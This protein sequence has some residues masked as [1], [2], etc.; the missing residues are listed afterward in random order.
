MQINLGPFGNSTQTVAP[1]AD[2]TA[3]GDAVSNL[4]GAV[5]N[6]AAVH[7]QEEKQKADALNSARAINAHEDYVLRV[8]E[9]AT[10]IA[11]RVST[12]ELAPE[13]ATAE[14]DQQVARIEA[15]NLPNRTP[16]QQE[17]SAGIQRRVLA[18]NRD[19][20]AVAAHNQFMASGDTRLDLGLDTLQKQ[21][22][23]P[24]A[25]IDLLNAKGEIFAQVARRAGVPEEQ[26]ARKL[27][28]FKDQNWLNHATEGYLA[29]RDSIPALKVMEHDLTAADGFYA[30][31]ID[32][33]RRNTLLSQVLARRDHVEEEA[34]RGAALQEK[35]AAKDAEAMALEERL[36]QGQL[37]DP[38][39]AE[40][41]NFVDSLFSARTGG[42]GLAEGSPEWRSAAIDTATRTGIVPSEVDS[43]LRTSAMTPDPIAGANAAGVIQQ[44]TERNPQVLE[45]L[46]EKTK[47][48][49]L[50]VA[51]MVKSGTPPILAV[52]AVR[53]AVF[54]T[55]PQEREL[56]QQVYRKTVKD[57][58]ADLLKM[59]QSDDHYNTSLFARTPKPPIGMV[60]DFNLLADTYSATTKG[61]PKRAQMLAYQD[62]QSRWG[63]S[64]V[65]GQAEI[66]R[67]PPE[68]FGITPDEVHSDLLNHYG[69]RAPNITLLADAATESRAYSPIDG[70]A[71]PLSWALIETDPKTGT[72]SV[73]PERYA[74]PGAAELT[75]KVREA[76]AA[77]V[78]KA[79]ATA[80]QQ[81]QLEGILKAQ[82]N[83]QPS[84]SGSI[85]A[86]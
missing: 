35:Q 22:G 3:I 49:G 59:L 64:E 63:R 44:L 31:K 43:W 53:K 58:G 42:A 34:L 48:F 68:R 6:L 60:A 20:V 17:L 27:Q 37:F 1:Q 71:L 54:G 84:P 47:S 16:A 4:G 57:P 75:A 41:R 33:N 69:E 30:E 26:V 61:D 11:D 52:P 81:L 23:L 76:R 9:A 65:N 85:G 51:D 45:Y 38:K 29:A 10:T 8:K 83:A 86:L 77:A 72:I 15:P 67:Y 56:Q 19:Y 66:M 50:Q 70:K 7:L 82:R 2:T 79:R 12:G 5:Y 25:N 21:G 18:D 28:N 74:L 14:Y 80:Q 36:L 46:D 62:L 32:V 39:D 40:H 13:E 78:A 55:T 73:L 24:G